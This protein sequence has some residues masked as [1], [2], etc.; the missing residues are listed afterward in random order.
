MR[1]LSSSSCESRPVTPIDN[2]ASE[3]TTVMMT[4][5]TKI[6]TSVKPLLRMLRH[7][8]VLRLLLIEGR[9]ADVRVVAVAA[10]LAIAAIGDDVV[11]APIRP[12]ARV[13]IHVA[14]RILGQGL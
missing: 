1:R 3:T 14:P 12:R 6:S 7:R 2:T 4:T 10:G 11:V 8:G 5:T 9:G 13:E